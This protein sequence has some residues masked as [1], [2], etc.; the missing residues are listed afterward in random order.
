MFSVQIKKIQLSLEVSYAQVKKLVETKFLD[1]DD[2]LFLWYGWP[3][4]GV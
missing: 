1:D 3:T 4:E 2:E